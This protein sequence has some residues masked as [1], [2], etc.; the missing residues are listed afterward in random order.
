MY[1]LRMNLPQPLFHGF[2]EAVSEADYKH[3]LWLTALNIS[4]SKNLG[5]FAKCASHVFLN[6]AY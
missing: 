1:T 3:T 5:I 4:L 2:N 6:P